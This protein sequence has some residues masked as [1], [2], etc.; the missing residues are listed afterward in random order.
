MRPSSIAI[1]LVLTGAVLSSGVMA[2]AAAE[3]A[4]CQADF[5]N[6]ARE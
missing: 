1:F 6:T 4:A 3:H 2:Q 5:N